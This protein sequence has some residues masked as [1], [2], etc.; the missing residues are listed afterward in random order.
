MVD[1]VMA[2][3]DALSRNTRYAYA[4]DLVF[5]AWDGAPQYHAEL[6][7]RFY[8]ALRV[9]DLKRIRFHDLRHTFGTLAAQKVPIH[10]VQELMGHPHISTTLIYTHYV[11][12]AE[13]VAL[14][15]QAFRGT[16]RAPVTVVP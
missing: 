7:A 16:V 14:L 10:T 2:A 4:D 12:A 15:G 13:E 1:D 11:P 9:A 3:L 6:R 5:P 8:A